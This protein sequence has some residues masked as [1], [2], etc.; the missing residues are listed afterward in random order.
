MK[1][2][3]G[4]RDLLPAV[5]SFVLVPKLICRAADNIVIYNTVRR[6]RDLKDLRLA[7][8]TCTPT[9]SAA[10]III[11]YLRSGRAD[12]VDGAV[13]KLYKKR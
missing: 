1:R 7:G 3:W 9:R 8:Y 13:R 11:Y 4:C 12:D 2:R 6:D 10:V 5:E